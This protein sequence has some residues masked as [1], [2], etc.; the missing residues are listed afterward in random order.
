MTPFHIRER[1]FNKLIRTLILV[2]ILP[3]VLSESFR[4]RR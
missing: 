3:M 2:S 1:L 4:E